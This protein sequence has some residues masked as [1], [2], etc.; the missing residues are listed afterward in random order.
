M[1]RGPSEVVRPKRLPLAEGGLQRRDVK[2]L[3][4]SFCFSAKWLHLV[5]IFRVFNLT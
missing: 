2:F 4:Q 1:L 5:L 3:F